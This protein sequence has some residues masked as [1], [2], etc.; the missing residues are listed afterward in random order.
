MD[1]HGKVHLPIGSGNL[2]TNSHTGIAVIVANVLGVSVEELDVSWGDTEASAW[3]FVSDASRAIH[4]HGKAMYNAALDLRRQLQ[5]RQGG[6]RTPRTDF[7]PY[8]DP[9][10]DINP[11]VTEATGQIVRPTDPKLSPGTEALARKIVANGG[12]VGLGLYVWNPSVEAWGASF[13]EVEVDMESG[14]VTVLKLVAA[15][16]CGHVIHRPGAEAQVHGG[17]IM[18]LGYAMTEELLIDPHSGIPMNQSLY[19]YRPPSLLDIP[20]L[21]TI[22]V[23]SPVQAGPFGAKGLGENPMFNAAA[24]IANAIFNAT[25]VRIREIPFTWHR[26]YDELKRAGKLA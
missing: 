1:R 20:P 4:C 19:E 5:K 17:S 10:T 13:A 14:Q 25:G 7:T 15:H 21:V 2:G 23:E 3:D 22:L 6:N 12:I 9:K 24:A 18:G 8:F 26:L 16:D 11:Y